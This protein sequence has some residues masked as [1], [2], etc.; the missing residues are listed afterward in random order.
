MLRSSS[1]IVDDLRAP[2]T[3][4]HNGFLG[5]STSRARARSCEDNTIVHVCD[6]RAWKFTGRVQGRL[7]PKSG[8]AGEVLSN[9]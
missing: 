7:W 4:V 2:Y 8:H 1:I 5:F 9:I 6:L 3:R